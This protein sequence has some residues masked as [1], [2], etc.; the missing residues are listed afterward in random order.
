MYGTEREKHLGGWWNSKN[1]WGDPGTWAPE[2]WNKII[3]DFNIESVADMGCGLG[4]ST[5]YFARKGLYA[6][7]I[8]GGSNAINNNVF[9]GF[10]IKNDY[11]KSSAFNDEE[12]DLVWCSEFV[13][14]VE[15]QFLDNILNDFKHSKY[16]AMSY[17]GTQCPFNRFNVKTESY[18]ID[19]LDSI[20]FKFKEE[21]SSELRQLASRMNM[22]RDF[23]HS[24]HLQK[25]LF[26]EKI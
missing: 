6:V 11:T 20:G 8:E 19:K 23:P 24:G 9:E 17:E 16:I 13:P 10:L 12:F 22:L 15:E 25:L 26:F 5:L 18:W 2:I 1:P 4:H 7:G 3:R 21:Y 14:Y